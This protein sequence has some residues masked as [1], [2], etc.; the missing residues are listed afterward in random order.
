MNS[1]QKLL[2][3]CYY[4]VWNDDRRENY[5][6]LEEDNGWHYVFALTVAF[7]GLNDCGLWFYRQ[8]SNFNNKQQNKAAYADIARLGSLSKKRSF[9]L[10]R[11]DNV[12]KQ[13]IAP[14][15][16]KNIF[17]DMLDDENE[18]DDDN[19]QNKCTKLCKFVCCSSKK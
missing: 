12:G 16:P 2:G 6:Y 9:S 11:S 14:A 1:K 13:F 15:L 4:M 5:T 10:R 19:T 18:V 8:F 7:L 3:L 17:K